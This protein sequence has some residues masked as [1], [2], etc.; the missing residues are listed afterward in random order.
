MIVTEKLILG[1]PR[2]GEKFIA[3]TDASNVEIRSVLYQ[4]QDGRERVV[5][6][7]RKTLSKAERKYCVT[8]RE[9]LAIVK[10][11]E[12]S[13]KYMDKSSTYAST[14]LP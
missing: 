5:A 1:L 8:C 4:V 10:M 12:H 7:L 2:P 9:L 6:Y 14:T 13:H 11:P 3:D